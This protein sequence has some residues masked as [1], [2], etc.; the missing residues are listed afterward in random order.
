MS[1]SRVVA[2]VACLCSMDKRFQPWSVL[3]TLEQRSHSLTWPM[4]HPPTAR[5][6]R[7]L[8]SLAWALEQR[9]WAFGRTLVV[10]ATSDWPLTHQFSSMVSTWFFA[11]QFHLA[12]CLSQDCSA[13]SCSNCASDLRPTCSW[14]GT[15]LQ[16]FHEGSTT[17][18]AQATS[19]N[20]STC[21][22]ITSATPSSASTLGDEVVVFSG[23]FAFSQV[24][25]LTSVKCFFGNLSVPAANYTDNSVTCMTVP[26]AVGVV[27][28]YIS[29]NGLVYTNQVSFT[30][31][32]TT[33]IDHAEM[34][35]VLIFSTYRLQRNHEW[36]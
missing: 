16:C 4:Q 15:N 33:N 7:A 21:P 24:S 9:E 27:P 35:K 8:L 29:V 14:C 2:L 20:S 5:T 32:G 12:N 28:A 17:C 22:T 34:I 23:S 1:I 10:E 36:L 19:S 26:A 18:A 11:S 25:S 6:F 30:F 13:T 31:Y 3:G